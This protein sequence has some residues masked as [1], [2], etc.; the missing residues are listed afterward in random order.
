[1]KIKKCISWD[2]HHRKLQLCIVAVQRGHLSSPV[3]HIVCFTKSNHENQQRPSRGQPPQIED[4]PLRNAI[5]PLIGQDVLFILFISSRE[6]QMTFISNII[7]KRIFFLCTAQTDANGSYT[8]R[9]NIKN[10]F[11]QITDL[12][13]NNK[14]VKK[15]IAQ[16]LTISV[17]KIFWT[18]QKG[19]FMTLWSHLWEPGTH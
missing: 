5:E 4:F 11:K 1:M 3:L 9:S 6:P 14:H 13:L 7:I 18:G 2:T 15:M 19:S 17:V 8:N 16:L 10:W 12:L